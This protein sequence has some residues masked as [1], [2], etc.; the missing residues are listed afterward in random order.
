MVLEGD[1][2]PLEDPTLNLEGGVW[3]AGGYLV[4]PRASV[5]TMVTAN[6]WADYGNGLLDAVSIE[7]IGFAGLNAESLSDTVSSSILTLEVLEEDFQPGVSFEIE[8][9]YT[10]VVDLVQGIPGFPDALA[11]AL[12]SAEVRIEG[13]FGKLEDLDL[14]GSVGPTDLGGILAG[15]GACAPSCDVDIDGDGVVGPSD[16][17]ALLAAWG[18]YID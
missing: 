16:L 17:G 9:V 10:R 3:I 7:L 4:D 15:W 13:V 2:Y 14:D 6:A 8:A 5:F 1:A 18:N 11:G 12:Y